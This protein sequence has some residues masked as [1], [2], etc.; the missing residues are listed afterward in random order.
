MTE[1]DGS[2]GSFA[3]FAEQLEG[4]IDARGSRRV[5]TQPRSLQTIH[6]VVDA[7]SSLLCRMP[8][9]ELTTTRI[10]AE[11]GISVGALYRFFPDKQT[12][13]DAVA[14]RHVQRFKRVIENEVMPKVEQDMRH[15]E[16]FR[17]GQVLEQ[18]VDAYVAY[19][20]EHAD[21]RTLSFGRHIS[22]ATKERESS[23][24]LGLPAMLKSFMTEQLGIPDHGELDLA[25]RVVSEAGERLIA[26]G[27]EQPTRE[28]RD[29]I[30]GEMKKMLAGY[31][32]P[33]GP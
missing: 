3:A 26:Y 31:L 27:Y 9:E 18:V 23:P 33:S 12:I 6:R 8:L 14:V 17:P 21:F 2:R 10:A 24:R 4:V 22:A 19:L 20:D 29:R 25:L 16:E 5:P 13:L 28:E 1:H 7:A 11:A 30:V 15:L 32:F